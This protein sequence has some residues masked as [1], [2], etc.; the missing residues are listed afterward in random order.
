VTSLEVDYWEIDPEWDGKIFRSTAQA[1][2][3]ARSGE[4]ALAMKIR[5][6]RHPCIRFVTAQGSQFQLNV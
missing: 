2:R 5:T 3:H 1:Q 4:L 6:G